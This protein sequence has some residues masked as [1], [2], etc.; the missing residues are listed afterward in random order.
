MISDFNIN[1]FLYILAVALLSLGAM[2]YLTLWLI[3]RKR[4]VPFIVLVWICYT[5][6]LL[7][8]G[9]TTLFSVEKER[10]YWGR[11]F[12][13]VTKAY[14]IVIQNL[15]HYEIEFSYSAW[16]SPVGIAGQ[17]ET[18]DWPKSDVPRHSMRP[19]DVPGRFQARLKDGNRIEL[20]WDAVEEANGYEVQ[21]TANPSNPAG[22]E[23]LERLSATEFVDRIP[24]DK[25]S[26][27]WF[28]RV[29]AVYTTPEDDPVYKELCHVMIEGAWQ[30]ADVGSIYTIRDYDD[31]DVVFLVSPATDIDGDGEIDPVTE[32]ASPIG[33]PFPKTSISR[34]AFTQ[35]IGGINTIPF[36]DDWGIWIAG[37]EPIYRPDGSIDALVCVDFAASIWTDNIYSAQLRLIS[38]LVF[39]IVLFFSGT[40]LIARLQQ[41]EEEQSET[42]AD[43]Q[44]AVDQLID[45][46]MRADVAARAKSHFLANMSHEIRT[47]M[48]AILGFADILGRR[49]LDCCDQGQLTENR[50]TIHLIKQSGSDLLTIINDILDFSKV[51]AE[52][53]EVE[54]IPT[55]P[56]MIAEDVRQLAMPRLEEKPEVEFNV[57]VDGDVPQHILID[58]T[59]LRQ[60]L[61]NLSVNA[62]KFSEKGTVLLRCR[63]LRYDNSEE[64]KR[65][66]HRIYGEQVDLSSFEGAP[67]IVLLQFLVKDEGIGMSPQQLD[68][69][70]QPFMQ[71][72]SS[73]TRRFGGTGLGLSISKRLA[74]LLG[75]DI[76]AESEEGKGSTF[77]L[78]I[79]P[80]ITVGEV[81]LPLSGIILLTNEEK[82]LE[83]RSIL[84][85]EDGK[86]NQIVIS[87]QLRD[88]GATVRIAENGKLALDA[89]EEEK[90]A[91][92]VVLMDMQMP[93]MDG[94][95][96]TRR[97]R[98]S[99]FTKPIIAVTAHALS[100]DSD[101]TLEMGCNAYVSKPIDRNLLIDM[102]LR[103][104]QSAFSVQ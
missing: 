11:Y 75:G 82:P 101:K 2:W 59:R 30:A 25:E 88:A 66:I 10:L 89:V 76:V 84:L 81:S 86:V 39:V 95:E 77:L 31:T 68:R 85:V 98:E 64:A 18:V 51:D 44:N 99:G 34:M 6:I 100:G 38:F 35:G 78:T 92:D 56:R 32:R 87:T 55:E 7:L 69:L 102:I 27:N 28:Y 57:E 19:L 37:V 104:D 49:L 50:Q 83:G 3:A 62:I 67:E 91:F 65:T 5:L 47:P 74:E 9:A 80:K 72:D 58:P 17:D 63:M 33:E 42:A 43:L 41:S 94:Y 4:H 90:G 15:G 36:T 97:L 13:E 16:S 22:W 21:R 96:A 79:A 24:S 45:A 23:L 93:V 54:W 46:K 1:D 14:A 103:F 70:F 61:A 12:S 53:I 73:L 8:G 29:R 26:V 71:A 40:V 20:D 48:N 60:I 52:Q